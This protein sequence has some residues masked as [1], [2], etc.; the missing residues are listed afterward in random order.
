M[1]DLKCLAYVLQC[2]FYYRITAAR[3]CMYDCLKE[4]MILKVTLWFCLLCKIVTLYPIHCSRL[5]R[6]QGYFCSSQ[7]ETLLFQSLLPLI[8]MTSAAI[9]CLS[10]LISESYGIGKCRWNYSSNN[11][12]NLCQ[13]YSIICNLSSF[14]EIIFFLRIQYTLWVLE[15]KWSYGRSLCRQ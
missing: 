13:R 8:N 4:N 1:V 12:W 5:A 10:S 15:T 14:S 11:F 3:T 2:S 9:F 7:L 6:Q